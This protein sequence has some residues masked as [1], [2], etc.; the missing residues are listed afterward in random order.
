MDHVFLERKAEVDCGE[1]VDHYAEAKLR[2]S[3]MTR[4][5][6]EYSQVEISTSQRSRSFVSTQNTVIVLHSLYI[7]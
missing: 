7:R 6:Y 3:E 4:F 5:S 1:R 2:L